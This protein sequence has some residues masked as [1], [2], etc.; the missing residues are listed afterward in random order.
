[1][2]C[3]GAEYGKSKRWPTENY[4]AVAKYKLDEGWAVWL[5][6]S[7]KDKSVKAEINRIT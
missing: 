6:G 7:G 1:V 5:F 4:A 2:L 3:P